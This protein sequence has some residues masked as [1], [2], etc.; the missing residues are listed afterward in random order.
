MEWPSS[1]ISVGGRA[2]RDCPYAIAH[3]REDQLGL[4]AG[5]SRLLMSTAISPQDHD[6]EG[7][8][9]GRVMSK[10]S[11]GTYADSSDDGPRPLAE[12]SESETDK[13]YDSSDHGGVFEKL[14]LLQRQVQVLARDKRR[15]KR[16]LPQVEVPPGLLQ[17]AAASAGATGGGVFSH[18]LSGRSS[19]FGMRRRPCAQNSLVYFNSLSHV[20]DRCSQTYVDKLQDKHDI[21]ILHGHG[22]A[23]DG[24]NRQRRA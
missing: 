20:Q 19:G 17:V 12:S 11:F 21:G 3:M 4:S 13:Q 5:G 14:R 2:D 15:K 8:K 24:G 9:A 10:P 1:R 23:S 7:S 22:H 16:R 6:Q 18:Q